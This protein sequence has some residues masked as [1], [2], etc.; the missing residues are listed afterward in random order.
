MAAMHERE[1]I[2]KRG[3]DIPAAVGGGRPAEDGGVDSASVHPVDY[4]EHAPAR[5][6]GLATSRP[7]PASNRDHQ[8][9]R[10]TGTAVGQR[11]SWTISMQKSPKIVDS[12]SSSTL[13][14]STQR[15]C[16]LSQ[17]RATR[18]TGT[19]LDSLNRRRQA[20]QALLRPLCR[21]C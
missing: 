1:P 18:S 17:V 10:L 6:I 20:S 15:A 11:E 19:P 14:P 5:R 9:R 8:P 4:L 7:A 13:C 16:R 21:D 3:S 12:R 2:H